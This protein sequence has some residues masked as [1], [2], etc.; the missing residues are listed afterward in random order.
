M[1]GISCYIQLNR[2]SF[3]GNTTVNNPFWWREELM[4][5][6]CRYLPNGGI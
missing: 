6:E 2:F 1:D 3:G 5:I 4:T